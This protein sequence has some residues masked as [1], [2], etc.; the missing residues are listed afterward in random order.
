VGS[1]QFDKDLQIKH[2]NVI[3]VADDWSYSQGQSFQVKFLGRFLFSDQLNFRVSLVS[4]SENERNVLYTSQT[5]VKVNANSSHASLLN[6]SNGNAFNSS[7]AESAI[8]S[9]SKLELTYMPQ[10]P[11][12]NL[13]GDYTNF[14]KSILVIY[15]F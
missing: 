6:S 7:S 15:F 11:N 1:D 3:V 2:N 9:F 10:G 4:Y 13:L 5:H 12:V 14:G 8:N